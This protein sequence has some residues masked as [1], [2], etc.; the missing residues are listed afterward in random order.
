VK[1]SPLV[2]YS[3]SLFAQ[4]D[5]SGYYLFIISSF[6]LPSKQKIS[7][8]SVA[9]SVQKLI[10]AESN[11][12]QGNFQGGWLKNQPS[13]FRFCVPICG[14]FQPFLWGGGAAQ[15]CGFFA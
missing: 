3:F 10:F 2:S 7:T 6:L 5:L 13:F 15:N 9:R 4:A 8:H 14:G 12:G 11:V 1:V